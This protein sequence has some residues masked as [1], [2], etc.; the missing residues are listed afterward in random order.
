MVAELADNTWR[1]AMMVLLLPSADPLES[2]EDIRAFAAGPFL[3]MPGR[4]A[5][6]RGLQPGPRN[7]CPSRADQ[8][9]RRGADRAPDRHVF[10][11]ATRS[12][13]KVLMFWST[14]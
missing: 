2:A 9:G 4:C 6:G 13:L 7:I 14:W 1:Y 12:G 10:V 8:F 3:P 5:P 11:A